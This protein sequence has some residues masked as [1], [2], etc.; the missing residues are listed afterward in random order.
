MAREK[1]HK[2]ANTT[3]ERI[4]KGNRQ[5][6]GERWERRILSAL[7]QPNVSVAH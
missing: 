1:I 4:Q 2:Y 7:A 5:R 6:Q 3:V